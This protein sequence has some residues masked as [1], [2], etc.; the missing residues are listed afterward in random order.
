ME[1]KKY[2]KVEQVTETEKEALKAVGIE[3]L[4]AAKR[5]HDELGEGGLTPVPSPNQFG[6]QALR[7]DIE[8]EKAVL[9]TLSNY[10]IPIRVISEEHGITDVTANPKY[11]GVLDG[12]DGTANYRAG[13]NKLRY[14]TM[15][16]M[17]DNL[18]PCYRD[19]IFS[20]MMEH[21]ANKLWYVR[22]GA[23][24]TVLDLN[25]QEQSG[26]KPSK[27]RELSPSCRIYTVLSYRET[28]IGKELEEFLKPYKT[29]EIRSC[30]IAYLDI[31]SGIADLEV[32]ITRKRNLEQMVAYGFLKEGGVAMVTLKGADLGREKYFEFG[33]ETHDII[34]TAANPELALDFLKKYGSRK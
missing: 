8:A 27:V 1:N 9:N 26:V 19:Y 12:I 10:K 34:I 24:S 15:F 29:D 5:V 18:D 3:A 33:Q 23:G 7:G 2:M 30:A 6:E 4:K 32:E 25:S 22:L 17:Y 21:S 16:G 14:A 28:P 11:L 20:G 13:R 31:A